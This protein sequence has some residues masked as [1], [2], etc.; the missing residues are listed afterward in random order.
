MAIKV[1][2]VLAL[3]KP[4]DV[5]QLLSRL[6]ARGYTFKPVGGVPNNAGPI[7]L[8]SEPVGPLVERI[9]N[10]FDAV[11]E[12]HA[13]LNSG[14]PLPDSPRKAATQWCG[15]PGGHVYHL[16]E[17]AR[18]S[19][20]QMVEVSID[21]SG[22]GKDKLPTFVFRDYGIGV[23][24]SGWGDT[25]LSLNRSNKLDKPY[26]AGAYGQGGSSTYAFCPFSV[27]MS[28]RDPRCLGTDKDAIGWT[29]VRVNDRD[30]SL[31]N[32]VYE[33]L[34]GPDGTIP[35]LPPTDGFKPGTYIAHIAYEATSVGR[36]TL[37]AYRVFNNLLFD[38]IL[39]YWLRDLRYK[40]NRAM[41]G[42]ASR[43]PNNDKLVEHH[44]EFVKEIGPN[45]H[46]TIRY[47][48]MKVKPATEGANGDPYLAGFLETAKSPNTILITLNGQK[49]GSIGK[50]FLK[51]PEVG[52]SFLSNY[53]LVQVECDDLDR[54]TKRNLFSSTREKT[55]SGNALDVIKIALREALTEDEDL[56][57]LE[58]E[59]RHAQTSKMDEQDQMRVR[60]LLDKFIERYLPSTKEVA[61]TSQT[62]KL[63]DLPKPQLGHNSGRGGALSDETASGFTRE[64]GN[65][66]PAPPIPASD[67]PT[68]LRIVS[69]D[70]VKVKVGGAVW[71]RLEC[72][73][74]DDY[75]TRSTAPGTIVYT[76]TDLPEAKIEARTG[77]VG[78]RLRVKVSA[79]E[80]AAPGAMGHLTAVL[81]R[82]GLES[83]TV[84]SAVVV[85]RRP[86][87]SVDDDS[88]PTPKATPVAPPYEI[89]AVLRGDSS[90][91]MLN[92]DE[93]VV[94]EHKY[95]QGELVFFINLSNTEFEREKE[96]KKTE[97]LAKSFSTKYMA[98]I[99]YNLWLHFQQEQ[100][101]KH[102]E[103]EALREELS[104]TASTVILSMRSE[105]EMDRDDD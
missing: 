95:S 1:S 9:T 55:R 45:S 31:K 76:L 47:W 37:G 25:L 91:E 78:G 57:R 18:Q 84:A 5:E 66:P 39:P 49:Q 102:F 74:P 105:T 63:S 24:P 56:Q 54:R 15:V 44:N 50:P 53:L 12:L 90:W 11:L 94:G 42:H 40:E 93:G 48:V 33:Y 3:S 51:Q 101:G 2:D 29:V 71:V 103:D 27:I 92:W 82:P 38:P 77:L 36:A 17:K 26:L 83:L 61:A 13:F 58:A 88:A 32:A 75:L 35:T 20:A 46:L 97:E 65:V 34:V 64:R 86:T 70:P 7:E 41:G 16:G 87:A 21:S 8:A 22:N 43:L 23:H 96:R 80:D 62:P 100:M 30:L 6:V 10:A 14:E 4:K 89:K 59:R 28:R 85:D 67:P 52:L 81:Q 99:A 98:M 19:V 69:S 68:F 60:R 104:R 73:A 72:D 79:S